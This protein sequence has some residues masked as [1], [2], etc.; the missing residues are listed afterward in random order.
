MHK[1]K[2]YV[3]PSDK[4]DVER[5]TSLEIL[6]HRLHEDFFRNNISL[7]EFENIIKFDSVEPIGFHDGGGC[8]YNLKILKEGKQASLN[9]IIR[10]H[11]YRGYWNCYYITIKSLHP[12]T[13][14][15]DEIIYTP[16]I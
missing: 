10:Q 2:F 15:C 4:W 5:L 11:D 1:G 3:E 16:Y 12:L 7:E 13:F 8:F 9:K 6:I 14:E